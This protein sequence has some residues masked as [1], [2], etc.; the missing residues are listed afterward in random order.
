[1][2]VVSDAGPLIALAKINALDLLANLYGKAYTFQSVYDE[3][4]TEGLALGADNVP[5]LRLA[6]QQA[7]LEVASVDIRQAPTLNLP[8][9]IHPGELDS[10]LLALQLQA[11]L[12]L[13][14]D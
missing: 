11:D 3:T 14:D 6:Y 13:I 7:L 4:I 8:K 1:M 5:E 10:I 12:L 2:I 9:L